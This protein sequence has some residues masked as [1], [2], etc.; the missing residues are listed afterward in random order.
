MELLLRNRKK[1]QVL[2]K[3]ELVLRMMVHMER[4]S[5]E[6]E[7]RILAQVRHIQVLV[8][9]ILAQVLRSL[10]LL[11]NRKLTSCNRRT[12]YVEGCRLAFG[13][14]GHS[15]CIRRNLCRSCMGH[16]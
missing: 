15:C 11:R 7:L 16:S 10:V 12:T 8:H 6:L 2:H 4:H 5:L 13:T 9:H 14:L 3:L 1:V